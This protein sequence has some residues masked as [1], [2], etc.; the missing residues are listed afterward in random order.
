MEE[1]KGGG[2][3]WEECA[4]YINMY[5]ESCYVRHY[6]YVFIYAKWLINPKVTWLEKRYPSLQTNDLAVYKSQEL[7]IK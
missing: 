2:W 5:C 4:L 7:G 3:W 1:G 6:W